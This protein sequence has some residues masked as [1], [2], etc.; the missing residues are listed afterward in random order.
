MLKKNKIRGYLHYH[1]WELIGVIIKRE[2][3]P[4][5]INITTMTSPPVWENT[6]KERN[7]KFNVLTHMRNCSMEVENW[8]EIIVY[9][10]MYKA[11]NSQDQY[12]HMMKEYGGI[13]RLLKY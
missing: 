11:F 7:S 9:I 8:D 12:L 1:N 2:L 5:T 3:L 6:K 4:E 13:D 10:S